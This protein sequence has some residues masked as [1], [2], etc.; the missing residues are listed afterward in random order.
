MPGKK[1]ERRKETEVVD[2]AIDDKKGSPYEL[3]L[4]DLEEIDEEEDLDEQPVRRA[5]GGRSR[6]SVKKSTRRHTGQDFD[7]DPILR[8][9][10]VICGVLGYIS[11]VLHFLAALASGFLFFVVLSSRHSVEAPAILGA[12]IV[13]HVIFGS[14]TWFAA[15]WAMGYGSDD[16]T[17]AWK[18]RA[19]IIVGIGI[20]FAPWLLWFIFRNMPR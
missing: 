3:Q 16:R 10:G 6:S 20:V 1:V 15:R 7:Y 9:I 17:E 18:A 2:D 5:R 4:D 12:T 14:V 19:K 8:V 11:S 13:L